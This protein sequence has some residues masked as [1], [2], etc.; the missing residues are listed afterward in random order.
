LSL[1]EICLLNTLS[2]IGIGNLHIELPN[3]SQKTK[4]TFKG[5]IHAPEM[6]FTLLSISRLDKAGYMV[7]FNRGMCTIK[8]PH[9]QTIATIP[10]S[11]GL[12]KIT[13]GKHTS[14]VASANVTS[15]KMSIT[16]AHK[17][18]GHIAHS[19]VKHTITNRLI[20]SIDLDLSSKPDFCEACAK[21]KSAR[22]PFPKKSDTRAEKFGERVHWDL[23][24]PASIKS[25][26]RNHYVAARI[27]DATRMVI[28]PLRWP[29]ISMGS[30]TT[31]V[32]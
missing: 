20:T 24:G 15:G 10:H 8:N 16:E 11:D 14:P 31:P 32:R 21:A 4:I 7:T 5:T 28:W 25:L 1:W 19:T 29:L 12:Y 13:A 27:D 9:G 18:L 26:N 23:W 6:A 2:T 17:K 22:Q 3:G 30:A